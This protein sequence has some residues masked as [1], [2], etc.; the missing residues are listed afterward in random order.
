[1]VHLV[2]IWAE[3]DLTQICTPSDDQII[4]VGTSVGS[5]CLYDLTDFE[6]SVKRE[7]LDYKLQLTAESPML[8]ESG[9]TKQIALAVKEIS[10]KYTVLAHTF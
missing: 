2:I 10:N 3:S 1:M 5:I 6:N 7:F 4:I 9:D 8:V